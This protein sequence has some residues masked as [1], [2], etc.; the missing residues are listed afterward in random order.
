MTISEKVNR[1]EQE[2]RELKAEIERL[3]R[4]YGEDYKPK[5]CQQC[6]RFR[7]HYIYVAG[8]YMKINEGTCNAGVRLKKKKATDEKCQYFEQ[9]KYT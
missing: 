6:K 7:E 4:Q 3:R 9:R 8:R 5:N 1:I 2:N